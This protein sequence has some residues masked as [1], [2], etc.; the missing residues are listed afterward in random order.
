M[1]DVNLVGSTS[2]GDNIRQDLNYHLGA[3]NGDTEQNLYSPDGAA[4]LHLEPGSFTQSNVSMVL[5]P[6]GAIPQPLPTGMIAVGQ[7]YALRASGGIIGTTH[8]AVLRRSYDPSQLGGGATPAVLSIARWNGSGWQIKSS[9]LDLEHLTVSA[10]VED[11]GIY[12]LLAALP[13]QGGPRVYLPQMR[14]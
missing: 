5:M 2:F 7:A 11:L 12:V 3:V 14:R 4:W 9:Q 10:V 1:G 13:D 6:T 8:A